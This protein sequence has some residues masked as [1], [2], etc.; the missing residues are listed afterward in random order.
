MLGIDPGLAGALC[1]LRCSGLKIEGIYDMPVAEGRVDAA[2]LALIVGMCQLQ[3]TIVAAV[4]R[5]GS[6]PHQAHAF[7]FGTDFGIVLGVLGALGVPTA[8][9]QP[10]QWKSAYGLRRATD[11]SQASTKVRARELASKL[12]P[13]SARLF[14]RVKDADRA[15]ASL[16]GRF[17]ASKN[18]WLCYDRG[19]AKV[20]IAP[21]R[22]SR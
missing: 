10:A 21:A 22:P 15:E 1:L 12:W 14:A 3:G 9:V 20:L 4:E 7:S 6:R 2:R 18:E 11:E 19:V 17:W 5:V 16:I 13:E 8:L